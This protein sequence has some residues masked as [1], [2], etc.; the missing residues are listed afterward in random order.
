MAID[1]GSSDN[2]PNREPDRKRNQDRLLPEILKRVVDAGV[3]K[4]SEQPE[5]LRHF[6]QELRL[7]KDVG[8]YL[9]SQI[10]ETKN[11]LY[12]AVASEVRGFLEHTNF[13]EQITNALTKLSFE[14]RTVIRFV[15]N[16]SQEDGEQKGL[17]KPE[18][19]S[20]VTVNKI[21]AKRKPA[22]RVPR[23]QRTPRPPRTSKKTNP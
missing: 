1:D 23:S 5:N 13:A 17:P 18:I 15:P 22:P 16:D 3:V 2:N 9:I 19:E 8:S 21:P 6:V 10:D 11:G 7:P 4:L 20:D 12:R 14:V